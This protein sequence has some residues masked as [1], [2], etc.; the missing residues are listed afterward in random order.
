MNPVITR[1]RQEL[2]GRADPEIRETSRRFFREEIQCFGIRSAAVTALRYAIELM[3]RELREKAM[4]KDWK[5][6]G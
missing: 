4:E 6:P 5:S 3:P 1:I 2:S